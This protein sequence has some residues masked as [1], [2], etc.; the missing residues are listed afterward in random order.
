VI[1]SVVVHG[2][3][4]GPL[5]SWYARSVA[6][7][8]LPE[9]REGSPSGLFAW[10]QDEVP[11]V[12]VE[13][14]A[15]ALRSSDPPLVLDVRARSADEGPRIPGDVRVLPD[16]VHEWAAHQQPGRPLVTYCT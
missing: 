12:T 4:A 3:S 14:L 15:E 6:R 5:T 16:R 10:S 13:E 8:T 7:E 1:L 9:E 11:R 2:V